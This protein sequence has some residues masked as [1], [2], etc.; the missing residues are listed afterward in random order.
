MDKNRLR[1][2]MALHNDTGKT[3]SRL[4]GISEQSFSMKM[5]EKEGR[6]FTKDEIEKISGLYSLS[7]DEIVSIFFK[8]IVSR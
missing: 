7:P 6:S 3:L 5:N 1:S 2:I 8:H 4:L